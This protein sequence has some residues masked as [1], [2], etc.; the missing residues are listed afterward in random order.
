MFSGNARPLLLA[1]VHCAGK[2]ASGMS[3]IHMNVR[4]SWDSLARTWMWHDEKKRQFSR[5]PEMIFGHVTPW[6]LK[7]SMNNFPTLSET[8]KSFE[9]QAKRFLIEASCHSWRSS[10]TGEFGFCETEGGDPDQGGAPA[11]VH[12]NYHRFG[13][14][15]GVAF[16]VILRVSG[17][18]HP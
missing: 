8:G 9:L 2:A 10:T 6:P 3:S 15:W 4:I 7:R 13:G 17:Q 18:L 1:H 11:I 12:D 16:G 14:G 5:I